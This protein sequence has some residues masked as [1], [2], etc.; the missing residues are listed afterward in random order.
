MKVTLFLAIFV[1]CFHGSFALD[2][3]NAETIRFILNKLEYLE[4]KVYTLENENKELK[5]RNHEL[6]SEIAQVK[7]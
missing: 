2:K 5:N 6:S 1:Y 3:S 7:V 4:N